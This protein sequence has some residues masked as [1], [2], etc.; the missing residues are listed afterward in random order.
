MDPYE[1]LNLPPNSAR[2]CTVEQVRHHYK[3]LARQ[4][5]PD[6][7]S[8]DVTQEDATYMFQLLT[9][10]YKHVISEIE[11]CRIDKTHTELKKAA[12]DAVGG[13]KPTSSALQ[14]FASNKGEKFN[15]AKFNSVFENVSVKS[16]SERGYSDWMRNVSASVETAE[17]E[18][19]RRLRRQMQMQVYKDPEPTALPNTSRSTRNSISYTELGSTSVD[20]YGSDKFSDYRIAHT[21]IRL[22]EEDRKAQADAMQMSYES[23]KASRESANFAM[24]DQDVIAERMR[25]R[26]KERA[27]LRRRRALAQQDRQMQEMYEKANRLLLN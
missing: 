19:Q 9:E 27:E 26:E 15:L 14:R 20:D 1:V 23:L 7:R 24:T 18:H 11:R 16:E 13:V 2:T 12:M 8:P 3:A 17:E 10:A 21:T 25:A 4:L 22:A 5:H 6:K